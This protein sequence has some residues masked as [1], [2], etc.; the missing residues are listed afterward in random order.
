VALAA[1]GTLLASLKVPPGATLLWDK[2]VHAAG[3]ALLSLL[4]LRATH[5]GFVAP[6][7]APS[8]VAALLASAHGIGI[9]IMQDYI[10][11]REGSVGD[12]VAN[13]VGVLAALA[14]TWG[15]F[16]FKREDG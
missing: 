13:V 7:P 16:A 8:A 2:A 12:A 5:G 1:A 4:A 10:P 6:R 9:E 14:A 15:W 3:Y 11:W